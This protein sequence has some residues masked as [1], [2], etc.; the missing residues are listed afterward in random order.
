M[1]PE[2]GERV[3][4]APGLRGLQDRW[5]RWSPVVS[6]NAGAA[7]LLGYSAWGWI[8]RSLL[9]RAR[10]C[11]CR[12]LGSSCCRALRCKTHFAVLESEPGTCNFCLASPTSARDSDLQIPSS[13]PRAVGAVAS[14]A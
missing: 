14:L 3:A 8:G 10:C 6:G 1:G 11:L 13:A 2:G 7:Q 5:D 12:L 9:A 4:M